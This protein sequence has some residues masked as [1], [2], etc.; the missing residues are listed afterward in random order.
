MP[1]RM[2]RVIINGGI[3][4]CNLYILFSC[5]DVDLRGL[6]SMPPLTAT[7]TATVRATA[8]PV[9]LTEHWCGD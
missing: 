8:R 9:I 6:C 1:G 7:A 4:L 2:M 3:S 5:Q